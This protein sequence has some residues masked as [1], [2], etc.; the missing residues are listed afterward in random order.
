MENNI[1]TRF[2]EFINE[3]KL[4]E[5]KRIHKW[6]KDD[7]IL[8]LY[9]VKHGIKDIPVKTEEE[10]AIDIIGATLQSLKM[11]AANVRKVLGDSKEGSYVLDDFSKIQ[12]KVV[13]DYKGMN[14]DELQEIV[15]DIIMNA[16]KIANRKAVKEMEKLKADE[17]DKKGLTKLN[18]EMADRQTKDGFIGVRHPE[19]YKSKG[20]RPKK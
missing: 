12:E 4:N 14:K 3:A 9:Y 20:T 19:R 15:D 6:T 8:T 5:G 11:Q 13:A 18:K 1:I 2:T 10:L 7:T 16:D 17:K